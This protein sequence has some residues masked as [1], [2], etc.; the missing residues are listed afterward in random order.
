MPY[1]I[2]PVLSSSPRSGQLIDAYVYLSSSTV[3]LTAK[4]FVA[5]SSS[6]WFSS[7]LTSLI[8]GTWNHLIY[9]LPPI[10]DGQVRQIGIQFG[11][12]ASTPMSSDVYIDAV[13]WN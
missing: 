7:N 6:R 4:V 11:T 2:S 3:D 12:S 10:I 5:N 13:G 1:I 9:P 8:P